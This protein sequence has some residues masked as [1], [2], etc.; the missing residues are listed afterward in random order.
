MSAQKKLGLTPF[1]LNIC[2]LCIGSGHP[3][4]YFELGLQNN[5]LLG[6]Q[7]PESMFR[8]RFLDTINKG[9]ISWANDKQGRLPFKMRRYSITDR[10]WMAVA[11]LAILDNAEE[12]YNYYKNFDG[13]SSSLDKF[14]K[15]D[16]RVEIQFKDR[17]QGISLKELFR[18][19]PRSA[20]EK[21]KRANPNWKSMVT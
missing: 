13:T 4:A 11:D 19:M 12:G 2:K 6:Q 21:I 1:H 3:P 17:K 18:N 20:Q 5:A 9:L 14:Q 7:V 15:K 8:P 10:G 16:R